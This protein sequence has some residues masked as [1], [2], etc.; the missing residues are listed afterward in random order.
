[1]LSM[2][3]ALVTRWLRNDLIFRAVLAYRKANPRP[4][5]VDP[6]EWI[7]RSIRTE[8]EQPWAAERSEEELKAEA[9]GEDE[10]DEDI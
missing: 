9:L 7:L 10:R 4:P 8:P 5:A 3:P 2:R 6:L 1:M